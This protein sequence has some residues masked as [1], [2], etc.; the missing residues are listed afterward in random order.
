MKYRKKIEVSNQRKEM[1]RK[2]IGSGLLNA[3]LNLA[4]HQFPESYNQNAIPGFSI[5]VRE[6]AKRYFFCET[7]IPGKKCYQ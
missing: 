6:T 3:S 2:V 5:W 4:R 1:S 7:K